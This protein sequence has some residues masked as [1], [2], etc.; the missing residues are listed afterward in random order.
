MRFSSS[1]RSVQNVDQGYFIL[2]L[3]NNRKFNGGLGTGSSYNSAMH[4]MRLIYERNSN[5]YT[6]VLDV[7]GVQRYDWI[8][9]DTARY[10]VS[11]KSK[12]VVINRKWIY[13][14]YI[15]ACRQ[16]GNEI[17]TTMQPHFWTRT[18]HWNMF[19]FFRRQTIPNIGKWRLG[20][21]EVVITQQQFKISTNFQRLHPGFLGP[22]TRL[23]RCGFC[24][25]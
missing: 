14:N 25:V 20:K 22:A 6:N 8:N 18:A 12:M 1:G 17:P 3:Y 7:F 4:D 13:K 15:S 10:R 11:G 19:L 2:F 9:V 23:E 16:D 21:P 5:G 24:T